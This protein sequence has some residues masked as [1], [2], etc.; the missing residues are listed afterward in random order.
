MK[1]STYI[2]RLKGELLENAAVIYEDEPHRQ[3]ELEER[4][5]AAKTIGDLF[6]VMHDTA[7]DVSGA[8]ATALK[9]AVEGTIAREFYAVPDR[10]WDT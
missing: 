9:I 4:I 3:E 8:V 2:M 10:G 6:A 1:R 5:D 7:F